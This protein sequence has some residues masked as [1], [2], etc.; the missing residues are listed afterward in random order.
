MSEA[1]HAPLLSPNSP[2]AQALE[3][4]RGAFNARF[5]QARSA[6]KSLDPEIFRR[7]LVEIVEPI[8]RSVSASEPD[9]VQGAVE[10]LFDL[11]LDLMGKGYFGE[12]PRCPE[13]LDTWRELLPAIP[14]LLAKSPRR[15][16]AA[17]TN[18]S[19]TLSRPGAA[20]AHAW[21]ASMAKVASH[22]ADAEAYLSAG[23][24]AAWRW[25]MASHRD[26]ALDLLA[27][28]PEA[29]ASAALDLPVGEVLPVPVLLE[30]LGDPWRRAEDA[31]KPAGAKALAIMGR[32]GGF[33]GFGGPFVCPPDVVAQAGRLLAFDTEGCYALFADAYGSSFERVPSVSANLGRGVGP[34][35]LHP[36]GAVARGELSM[37]LPALRNASSWACT[38]HTLAVAIPESHKITL[39]ALRET[40]P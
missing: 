1:A 27:S 35:V 11:S 9:K 13:L 20:N 31:K 5:A 33:R 8:A 19:V 38:E 7:H 25:G 32:V 34:F 17:L 12:E 22:C 2:L 29:T 21:I 6:S 40:R 18:A 23:K 15:V 28:M 14:G 37:I 26:A 3:K 24:V 16:A 10:V 39:V 30:A 36:S 4:G